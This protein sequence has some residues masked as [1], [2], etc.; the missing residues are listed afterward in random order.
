MSQV[1]KHRTHMHD[2]PRGDA[3]HAWHEWHLGRDF[4]CVRLAV[5][6]CFVKKGEEKYPILYVLKER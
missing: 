3:W 4:L 5:R 6:F 1:R 2:I